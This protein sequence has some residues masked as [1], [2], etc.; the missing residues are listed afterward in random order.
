MSTAGRDGLRINA[1]GGRGAPNAPRWRA[2]LGRLCTRNALAAV[3]AAGAVSGLATGAVALLDVVVDETSTSAALSR[4]ATSSD[5]LFGSAPRLAIDGYFS[6]FDSVRQAATRARVEADVGAF[7]TG[8]AS[9]AAY[10]V[11]AK[12]AAAK[13]HPSQGYIWPTWGTLTGWFGEDRTTHLH[14]G[15]DIA[16]PPGTPVLAIADGVVVS[17]GTEAGGAYGVA[18]V[19]DHGGGITT[20]YAHFDQIDVEVG[21]RVVQGQA[22][23]AM[24]CTGRCTGNHL[25]F[26]FRRD[27]RPIDP[28]AVLPSA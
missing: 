15:V 2:R 9:R 6:Q 28:F 17:A 25:H 24:G 12:R 18:I 5:A 7:A 16:G 11:A 20:L 1:R 27:G 3:I 26:E 4:R 19:V 13:G 22:I 23:G 8:R 10:T 14:A 21:E